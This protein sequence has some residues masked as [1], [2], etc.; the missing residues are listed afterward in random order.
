LEFDYFDQTIMGVDDG[1]KFLSNLVDLGVVV[2][3]HVGSE[4][5]ER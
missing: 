3:A 5:P 4:Y 1:V 2:E